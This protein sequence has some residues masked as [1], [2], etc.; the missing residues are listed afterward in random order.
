MITRKGVSK[1]ASSEGVM[2]V[3]DDD[4]FYPL[5][6]DENDVD[7]FEEMVE[8]EEEEEYAELFF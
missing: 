7:A 6:W 2:M 8:E 1:V 3:L 4:Q 5:D